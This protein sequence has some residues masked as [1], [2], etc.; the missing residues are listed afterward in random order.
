MIPGF[1]IK[2]FGPLG[3]KLIFFGG[4]ALLLA[5]FCLWLYLQ[6]R[7]DGRT[8]EVVKQQEREIQ[9]KEDLGNASTNSAAARVDDAVE[10]ERQRGE[11][12]NALQS[13]ADPDAQRRARGCRVLAQQGRDTSR[14]AACRGR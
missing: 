6:G 13:T 9:V 1:L 8:G 2:R 3:A 11:L 14:I 12:N 7:T 4:I 5:A 10:A